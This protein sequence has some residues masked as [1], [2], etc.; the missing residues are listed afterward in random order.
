[1]NLIDGIKSSKTV[2]DNIKKEKDLNDKLKAAQKLE[3][4][5]EYKSLN[6]GAML[7]K[8]KT[9]LKLINWRF[10]IGKGGDCL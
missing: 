9:L 7:E 2:Q 5:N 10:K 1:M 8:L 6:L 4:T 3:K